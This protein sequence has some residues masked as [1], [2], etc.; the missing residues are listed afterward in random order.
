[1]HNFHLLLNSDTTTHIRIKSTVVYT[2]CFCALG[3]ARILSL[4]QWQHWKLRSRDVEN[5]I[6]MGVG[7]RSCRL[8]KFPISELRKYKWPSDV[9]VS[10]NS[11]M[12]HMSTKICKYL[13]WVLDQLHAN[14]LNVWWSCCDVIGQEISRSTGDSWSNRLKIRL[15]L[16]FVVVKCP[17][18]EL[19]TCFP[20]QLHQE[21]ETCKRERFRG[22]LTLGFLENRIL[23]SDL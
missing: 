23:F 3:P 7:K 15:W 10:H 14:F 5:T 4:L 2:L 16:K 12:Q 19:A 20:T 22:D 13:P 11:H 6:E 17:T 21:R 8:H 1:M 18:V 9:S